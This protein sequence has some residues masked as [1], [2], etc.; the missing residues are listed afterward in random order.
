M[1]DVSAHIPTIATHPHF[2]RQ[3]LGGYLLS[4]LLLQGARLGCEEATLEVRASNAAA[5][6][7]YRSFGFEIV[8]RR[9]RYYSDNQ[10]D[11]LIMTLSP[12][13]EQALQRMLH[14]RAQHLLHHFRV[15]PQAGV[16]HGK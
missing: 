9:L 2:A 14:K 7:L 12:L 5:Q 1:A 10:E 3:G 8:G 4:Y 15:P 13:D 11:A 16:Q 6:A